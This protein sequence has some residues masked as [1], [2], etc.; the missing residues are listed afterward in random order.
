MLKKLAVFHKDW[1]NFVRTHVSDCMYSEDIVQEMYLKTVRT[2]YPEKFLE[3]NGE[4]NK[5]YTLQTLKRLC[6]DYNRAKSRVIKIHVDKY[7]GSYI[8][9]NGDD[10]A[11]MLETDIDIVYSLDIE[12]IRQINDRHHEVREILRAEDSYWERLY[13]IR[14]C[15]DKP[16]YRELSKQTGIDTT[17]LFRDVEKIGEI[18]K[19]KS[20]G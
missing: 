12:E 10:K 5:R 16:T 11:R 20:N 7:F 15:A 3:S 6:I 13:M 18:I 8:D 14:T 2:K 9:E 1:L 17:T 4:V 19:K